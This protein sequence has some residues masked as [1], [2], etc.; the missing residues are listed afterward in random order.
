MTSKLWNNQPDSIKYTGGLC[1]FK[2]HLTKDNPKTPTYYLKGNRRHQI[3][4]SRLCMKCSAL[5]S[6]PFKMEIIDDPICNCEQEEDENH[7]FF[8]CFPIQRH[9]YYTTYIMET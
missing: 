8:H 2:I 1:E 9:S 3:L 7:Y 4:L 6:H 5:K